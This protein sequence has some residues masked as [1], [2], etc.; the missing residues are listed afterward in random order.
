MSVVIR[1][2]R[3]NKIKLYSKGADTIVYELLDEKSKGELWDY[4]FLQLEDF[5]RVG[6]RTLVCAYKEIPDDV[7]KV[8]YKQYKAGMF[9]KNYFN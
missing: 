4:S 9:D 3:T 2:P 5:A 8:W 1:D 7:F 6:L